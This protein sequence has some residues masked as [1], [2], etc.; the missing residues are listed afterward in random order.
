MPFDLTPRDIERLKGVHPD[1]V[2]VVKR[3]AQLSPI[4]F[5]VVEGMRTLARQ[6]QLVDQGAS[7]TMRSRHLTGHAVDLAPFVDEDADGDREITWH[8]GHYDR[9]MPW[10]KEA[11]KQEGVRVTWGGS[12]RTFVD[13]AHW[14]LG[15]IAYP[16]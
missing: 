15:R 6:K 2:R 14:E 5:R 9:L 16:A 10:I 3:A 11:A 7:T 13:K 12:W 1:L 4:E 8:Q